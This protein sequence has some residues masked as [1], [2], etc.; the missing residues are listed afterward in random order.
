MNK[1]IAKLKLEVVTR[2]F[3]VYGAVSIN[4]AYSPIGFDSWEEYLKTII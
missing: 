2:D 1:R 4:A 3:D